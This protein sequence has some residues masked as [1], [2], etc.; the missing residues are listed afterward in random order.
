MPTAKGL[1]QTV[2]FRVTLRYTIVNT[3]KLIEENIM[4]HFNTIIIGA[5]LAGLTAAIYS[6]RKGNSTL[7]LESTVLGGQ[8]IYVDKVDNYPALPNTSGVDIISAAA[9]QA[10][11]LGAEIKYEAAIKIDADKTVTTSSNEYTADKIIIAIGITRK[12]LEVMGEE[13]LTGRGISYCAVC[14]GAFYKSKTAIVIG[15][16]K[17]ANEDI[18]FLTPICKNVIH[19]PDPKA[20]EEIKGD[21]AVT[22]VLLTDGTE[23]PTDAVFV[24]VGMS[25]NTAWLPQEIKRTEKGFIIT[26]ESC[27]TSLDGIYAAGDCRDKKHRQLITAAADGC[28]AAL[29]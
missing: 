13:P 18:E 5:G 1:E 7:L 6:A 19:L 12:K 27:Q 8:I 21:Q 24:A 29:S 25:V 16:G 22:S 10:Q 9:E 28:I 2:D 26:D 20:I 23:I 17:M 4:T 11:S 3:L 15:K 14:D